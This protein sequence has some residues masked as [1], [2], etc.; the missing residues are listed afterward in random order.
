MLEERIVNLEIKLSHQD[1]LLEELN[2]VIYEQQKAIDVIT[3]QMKVLIEK[4]ASQEI[5]SG[6]EKPPHY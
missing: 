1:V 6:S 3:Q 5:N 2:Q 4:I